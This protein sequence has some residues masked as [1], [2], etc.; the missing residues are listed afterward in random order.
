MEARLL[1]GASAASS[2][3]AAE[4]GRRAEIMR[5]IWLGLRLR[6]GFGFGFSFGASASASAWAWAWASGKLLDGAVHGQC[7]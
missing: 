7:G 5:I 2:S 1:W 3:S 6:F 4:M